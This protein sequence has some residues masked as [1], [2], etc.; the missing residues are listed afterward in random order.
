M[1]IAASI[2]GGF[3]RTL[4]PFQRAAAPTIVDGRVVPGAVATV[5]V[6][7]AIFPKSSG[8]LV[9]EPEGEARAGLISI[10]A[11]DPLYAGRDTGEPADLVTWNGATYELE[12]VD[13][14]EDG[15]LYVATAR[16]K[17]V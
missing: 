4:T 7:A 3:R 17:R 5:Q 14:F 2:I 16:R 10:Y 1:S 8:R 15:G 11:S 13:F 12:D 9:R 6:L